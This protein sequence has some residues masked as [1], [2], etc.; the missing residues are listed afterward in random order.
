MSV[1]MCAS[2]GGATCVCAMLGGKGGVNKKGYKKVTLD[3]I[4]MWCHRRQDG[5][6]GGQRTEITV[7][8][9]A[10]WWRGD[11]CLCIICPTCKSNPVRVA[12]QYLPFVE[13]AW[14]PDLLHY[15]RYNPTSQTRCFIFT[16]R[17]STL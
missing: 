4:Q 6:G 9:Y 8:E 11:M 2:G 1:R 16:S 10:D 3:V 17:I 14:E 15:Y 12:M 5:Y 7:R 13:G